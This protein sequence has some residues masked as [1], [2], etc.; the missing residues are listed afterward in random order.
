MDNI[1]LSQL[2]QPEAISKIKDN[3]QV[4]LTIIRSNPMKQS[5]PKSHRHH[6]RRS[7]E[8]HVYEDIPNTDE[9]LILQQE[10]FRE[11]LGGSVEDELKKSFDPQARHLSPPVSHHYPVDKAGNRLLMEKM[12][13]DSGLS[14]G[15]SSVPGPSVHHFNKQTVMKNGLEEESAEGLHHHGSKHSY[16]SEREAMKKNMHERDIMESDQSPTH[17]SALRQD[18]EIEVSI[19]MYQ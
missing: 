7:V 16:R 17:F 1:P 15:S 13:K 9:Q 6:H 2:A 5:S 19:Y 11:R 8:N 18:Y 10:K 14:S 4:T 3:P 12:S